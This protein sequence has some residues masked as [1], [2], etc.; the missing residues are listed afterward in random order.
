VAFLMC[1][2]FAMMRGG[3]FSV[4]VSL[5]VGLV[6]SA[7]NYG[8]AIWKLVVLPATARNCSVAG[9]GEGGS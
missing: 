7:V 3:E 4:V 5:C 1:M 8:Y 2:G 6:V 9:V